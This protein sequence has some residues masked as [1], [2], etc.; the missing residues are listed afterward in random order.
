MRASLDLAGPHR[1]QRLR[2]VER[3]H[4]G[5]LDQDR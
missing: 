1:Q 3:L 4:L 5:F 2:T